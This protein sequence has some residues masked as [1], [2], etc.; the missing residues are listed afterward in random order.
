MDVR[1]IAAGAGSAAPAVRPSVA[2]RSALSGSL[3]VPGASVSADTIAALLERLATPGI[4]DL[5]LHLENRRTSVDPGM[6]SELLRVAGVA[7]AAGDVAEVRKAVTQI[8]ERNP[9]WVRAVETEPALDRV[10]GHTKA[11]LENLAAHAR[12]RAEALL[13][14]ARAGVEAARPRLRAAD[15]RDAETLLDLSGRLI[16][17]GR[18]VDYVRSAELSQVL[19]LHFPVGA[20]SVI[21]AEG[22]PGR[23]VSRLNVEKLVE[24]WKRAPV[25]VLLGGW[26][27]IGFVAV[28]LANSATAAGIWAAGFLA[29][30]AYFRIRSF[31][32]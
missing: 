27:V 11:V 7:A 5:I 18:Q 21:R 4:S 2:D 24:W 3:N 22:E 12:E 16:E 19:L 20:P 32:V 6:L 9:E 28:L 30:I 23:A 29:F 1:S 13:E 26:V 15:V 10:R 25:L 14:N 31:R 8:V 17:S